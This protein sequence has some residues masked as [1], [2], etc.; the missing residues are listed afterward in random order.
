MLDSWDS[1]KS[2]DAEINKFLE[3]AKKKTEESK[4]QAQQEA[5]NYNQHPTSMYRSYNVMEPIGRISENYYS[6]IK[7]KQVSHIT[8]FL[9]GCSEFILLLRTRFLRSNSLT[10]LRNVWEL[11]VTSMF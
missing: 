5:Q 2:N 9:L 11:S 1:S 10:L 7:G 6:D 8:S 4:M 3:E